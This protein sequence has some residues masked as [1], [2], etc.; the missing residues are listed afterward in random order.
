MNGGV[1]CGICINLYGVQ[2]VSRKFQYPMTET[3]TGPIGA[4]CHWFGICGLRLEN[5]RDFGHCYLFV[6]WDLEFG[7]F[8]LGILSESGEQSESFMR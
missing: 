7:A 5:S 4:E 2:G 8:L 6:I 3:A 1:F